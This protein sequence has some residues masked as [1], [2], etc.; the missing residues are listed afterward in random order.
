MG[1]INIKVNGKDI[2]LSEFPS[3]ILISTI[4]GMLKP[5]KGVNEIKNVEI[6]FEI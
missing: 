6:K 1:K 3:E 2:L 4:C 5:L